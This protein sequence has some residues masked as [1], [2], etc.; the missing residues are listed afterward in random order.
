MTHVGILS[1]PLAI[2]IMTSNKY[3]IIYI[4]Y[5]MYFCEDLI[6]FA[7]E[8]SP[9]GTLLNGSLTYLYLPNWHAKLLR[10]R[11]F[12]LSSECGT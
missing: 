6:Y 11:I 12:H 9:A 7:L 10:M 2:N 4:K 5:I 8:H 3:V 1:G